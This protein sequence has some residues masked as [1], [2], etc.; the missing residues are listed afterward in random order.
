VQAL[1]VH[2]ERDGFGSREEMQGALSLIPARNEL[3]MVPG[4]GHELMSA[5]NRVEL[6]ARIVEAFMHFVSAA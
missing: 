6:P 3:M 1:F 2:G 5:R 4:S